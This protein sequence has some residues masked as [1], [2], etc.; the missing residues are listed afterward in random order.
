MLSIRALAR[1]STGNSLFFVGLLVW[2]P[3]ITGALTYIFFGAAGLKRNWLI[4]FV[5]SDVVALLCFLG[6][7]LYVRA[8]RWIA[9]LR[10]RPVPKCSTAHYFVIAACILPLALPVGLAVGSRL[11][12]YTGAG[13]SRSVEHTYRMGIGFG[14]VITA[15]FFFQ[16]SRA[17]ARDAARTAQA[18]IREL[19]NLRLAAQLAAL[20][21]EMNPHLL[22]NALNT[23]ASLIHSDPDRAEEVVIQLSELYR[24]VLRS[25]RASMH[26]LRDELAICEAYLNVEK[27]RFGE[28]LMAAVHVA[29]DIA[30]DQ[31]RVPVLIVQPFVEN[32]VKHGFASRMG[33]GMV[34]LDV[35]KQEG[36]LVVTVDDDGVGLGQ[37]PQLGAG[38]ATAN[39]RERLRLSYGNRASIDIGPR[40]GGGTRV[41]LRLPIETGVSDVANPAS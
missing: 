23:V 5:I 17:D 14:L 21:A 30:A 20:S 10:A 8:Q 9:R 2:N 41:S 39:C 1:P 27:A 3:I 28:R 40:P 29:P 22:F 12:H 25:A 7:H 15:L 24:G 4:N 36:L 35:R 32:A 16:R 13:W 31:V 26:S 33:P 6:V 37:S 34:S 11:A 19:E 38:K 18:R